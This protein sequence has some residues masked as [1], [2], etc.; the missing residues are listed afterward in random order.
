MNPCIAIISQNTLCSISLRNMLWDIYNNVEVLTYGSM[1]S[2]IRDSNRH[3]VHFFVDS[4]LLF[5]H[6]DEFETLK[7]QTSI[8]SKG[9]NRHLQSAGFNILDISRAEHEIRD[10]LLHLQFIISASNT[11]GSKKELKECNNRLSER[12]KEVL[13]SIVKGQINKEIAQTL[14]ISLPTVIFHR[15][16]ICDK[17]NTRS[18]GRLTVY[19]IL[20]GIVN[21]NEI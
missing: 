18:L 3:F 2:F 15:N 16:N 12:E 11:I 8:I 6:V 19:A 5:I 9:Q 13:A 17:L 21:I 7:T 4:D 20:S 10:Q 1:D 14:G